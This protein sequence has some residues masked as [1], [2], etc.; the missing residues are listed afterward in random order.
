M[1]ASIGLAIFI[2]GIIYTNIIG[3]ILGLAIFV[4]FIGHGH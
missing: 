2:L 1:I 4:I 3:V